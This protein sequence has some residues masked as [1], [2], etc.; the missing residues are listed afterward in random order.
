[1]SRG[2][3]TASGYSCWFPAYL[4][5]K[6]ASVRMASALTACTAALTV[7]QL[8]EPTFALVCHQ[9]PPACLLS[10]LEN[11]SWPEEPVMMPYKVVK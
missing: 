5:L 10:C 1:M 8:A 6:I 4:S 9:L 2:L 11:S 7:Q 3:K